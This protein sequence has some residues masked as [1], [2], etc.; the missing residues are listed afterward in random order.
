MSKGA[1][2]EYIWYDGNYKFRSKTRTVTLDMV[3][4]EYDEAGSNG[5]MPNFWPEWNYDGSS[6]NQADGSYSEIILKPVCVIPDPFNMRRQWPSFIILCDTYY[7][8]GTPTKINHRIKAAEIFKANA[9]EHPWFGLEQEYFMTKENSNTYLYTPLGWDYGNTEAQGKYYCGVGHNTVFGRKLA[10][11]HYNICLQVGLKISGINAEVAPGQWEFQIG[12]CEGIEAG[13]HLWLARYLL[14][15][16]AETYEIAIDFSPKPL[17]GDWN[18]SGCHANF[19]TL[20]MREGDIETGETGLEIINKAIDKL[21][22]KHDEH[23]AVYGED[24]HLR[25]TGEHETSD[26]RKFTNGVA[27]RGCSVRI[28]TTVLAKKQGY[29]EDRR[30]SSNCDPYLVT[31]ILFETSIG[32]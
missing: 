14:V 31:S 27:N 12:P 32:N 8:D 20:Q 29:F 22:L 3:T 18:G 6:T 15:R 1:I 21:A 26:Y 19:S 13:D 28:P 16:L 17:K 25:M 23:M 7:P 9:K 24:N 11:D 30:P 5:I 4:E 10:E 2:G